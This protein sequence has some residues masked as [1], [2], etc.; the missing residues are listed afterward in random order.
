MKT[1]GV[2]LLLFGS[3]AFADE[4]SATLNSDD[5]L[6]LARLRDDTNSLE[7]V[8][9]SNYEAVI[10][11]VAT[12]SSIGVVGVSTLCH[13]SSDEYLPLLPKCTDADISNGD[14][15]MTNSSGF[16]VVVNNKHDVTA[17][18]LRPSIRRRALSTHRDSRNLE[19]SDNFEV[20]NRDLSFYLINIGGALIS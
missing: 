4:A 2:L 15:H 7:L 9:R 16:T 11:A 1:A 19:E 13:P 10:D 12:L 18:R 17:S 6:E 20:A 3:I 8:E 14:H 5:A